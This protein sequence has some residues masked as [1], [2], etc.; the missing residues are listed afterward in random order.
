MLLFCLEM[1]FHTASTLWSRCSCATCEQRHKHAF[2]P[3]FYLQGNWA[4]FLCCELKKIPLN[5]GKKSGKKALWFLHCCTFCS[6]L[7]VKSNPCAMKSKWEEKRSHSSIVPAMGNLHPHP[8]AAHCMH[9]WMTAW[10]SSMVLCKAKTVANSWAKNPPQ[11][12]Q[13]GKF[14]MASNKNIGNKDL[15]RARY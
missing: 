3:A 5:W 2:N 12:T 8:Q 1:G 6:Q 4:K 7:W 11:G 10:P 9:R 14:P 15:G 13:H